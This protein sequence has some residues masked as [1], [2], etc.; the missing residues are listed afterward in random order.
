MAIY[1]QVATT[2]KGLEEVLADEIFELGGQDIEVLKRA[3]R[4]NGSDEILYKANLKLRTALRV[5]VPIYSFIAENE[6]DLYREI[7]EY[8]WE[9]LMDNRNTF[10]IDAIVS[11]TTFTHS[12]YVALK[13]KDAIVDRFRNKTG[14]RPSIDTKNPDLKINIHV[15]RQEISVSLDSTGISL[16]RRGYRTNAN[17]APINEALAA[18]IILLSGWDK[19]APFLDPM[20]GSGTF[21]I[22]AAY[23][24]ANIPPG[25]NRS[26]AFERWPDFNER[27]FDRVYDELKNQIV[28]PECKF[29]CSDITTESLGIIANNASNA[30]VEEYIQ[31]KEAD[32]FESSPST[33]NGFIFLNPPYG[34]RL[35]LDNIKD[36]YERIGDTLKQQYAG[37]EAWI[38]SSDHVALK[39]LGLRA[40][41]KIDL[42]NGGLDARLQQYKMFE[43]R[44]EE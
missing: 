40:D 29:F 5:L 10:A 39:V 16:D 19:K 6:H 42:M 17:E 27:L 32:F 7:H 36:F 25:I 24:A 2:L 9:N 11:G 18:G 20:A 23:I 13:T 38:I 33:E 14:E 22:E 37:F 35:S 44:M 21:S 1:E 28:D 41:K 31:V 8:P 12:Q 43:G 4:F 26:F 30:G 3:V 15:N 34:E